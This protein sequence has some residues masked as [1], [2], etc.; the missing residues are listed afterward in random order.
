[1]W[2]IGAPQGRIP[3]AIFTK[4]A[5]FV[6]RFRLRWLLKLH[7]ICSR[8]YG[9]M[10]VLSWRCLVAPKSSAPHSGET[11]RQ[12]PRNFRDART[13]SR[14]S[15]TMPSLVGLRF[16]P[17]PRQP[18][19]L[20]FFVCLSVRHA[21]VAMLASAKLTRQ[22]QCCSCIRLPFISFNNCST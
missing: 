15:I 3:C 14:S 7:S 8:D 16:H 12:T 10:G 20:S 2:N 1:M 21:S 4:F 5:E 9:V 19:T 18:K 6:P 13:C 22:R 17:P 11:M